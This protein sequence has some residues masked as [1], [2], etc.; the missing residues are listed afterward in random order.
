[1][2]GL[3]TSPPNQ[4]FVGRVYRRRLSASIIAPAAIG[5]MTRTVASAS[6]EARVSYQSVPKLKHA[7]ASIDAR[8]P[9]INALCRKD[10]RSRTKY[11]ATFRRVRFDRAAT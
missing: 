6:A 9:T 10:V 2:T 8:P 5:T 7:L 1:M 11:D 3:Q 4:S